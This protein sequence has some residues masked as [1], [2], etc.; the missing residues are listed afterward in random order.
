M[1]KKQKISILN[2]IIFMCSIGAISLSALFIVV[3]VKM[4]R[5][6]GLGVVYILDSICRIYNA[7]NIIL[8]GLFIGFIIIKLIKILK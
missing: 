8:F 1:N 4:Y 2:S 6:G 7:Y 5:F 3:L